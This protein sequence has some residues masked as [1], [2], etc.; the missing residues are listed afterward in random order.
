MACVKLAALL[1]GVLDAQSSG[2]VRH[3]PNDPSHSGNGKT[4]I[5]GIEKTPVSAIGDDAYYAV[6]D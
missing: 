4:P 1:A 6:A 3:L 2:Y 5:Q